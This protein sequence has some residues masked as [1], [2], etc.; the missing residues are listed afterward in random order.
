MGVGSKL[1]T[2]RNLLYRIVY[3]C[4]GEARICSA[5]KEASENETGCWYVS[6][7]DVEISSPC[8]RPRPGTPFEPM[9]SV[10]A[11]SGF[12]AWNFFTSLMMYELTPPQRPRSE[13][14]GT[15]SFDS[16]AS[17]SSPGVSTSA[18]TDV[19]APKGRAA[20]IVRCATLSFTDATTFIVL[21]RRAVEVTDL[22]RCDSACRDGMAPSL[23][24][25]SQAPGGEG[26]GR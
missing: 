2:E 21:V 14:I 11:F 20:S 12:S 4:C 19:D 16:G 1:I 26:R 18:S 6:S 10:D 17:S 24:R 9:I 22:R 25:W 8:V 15:M 23:S 13:V 3:S 5:R 7:I